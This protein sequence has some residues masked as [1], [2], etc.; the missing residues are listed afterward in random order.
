MIRFGEANGRIKD[1]HD[2]WVTTRTFSFDLSNLV[3][4][5]GGTLRRRETVIP[6][7]TGFLRRTPQSLEPPAFPSCRRSFGASSPRLL[8]A[9]VSPRLPGG[10][11]TRTVAR[12]QQANLGGRFPGTNHIGAYAAPA[13]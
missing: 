13:R 8:P 12:G 5:L 1:F 3:E 7:A 9:L 2:I 6:I 11:G 4:A 10:A